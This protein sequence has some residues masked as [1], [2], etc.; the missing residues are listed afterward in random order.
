[1]PKLRQT[2][3]HPPGDPDTERLVALLRLKRHETPGDDYFDRLLPR[4]HARQRAEMLRGSSLRL[5]AER[6]G[7][8]L[9]TLA[10]GRWVA[11]GLAAYAAILIAAI[12]VLQWSAEPGNEASP[13]QAVSLRT[14]SP[15]NTV[16]VQI[17]VTPVMPLPEVAPPAPAP[18][19][20]AGTPP[21]APEAGK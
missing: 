4:F 19:P 13:L 9:D 21:I 3:D 12:F 6:F 20:K 10:G 7:V 2:H 17:R 15:V 16:P 14:N 5:F 11:G 8:F 18:Q 1:M